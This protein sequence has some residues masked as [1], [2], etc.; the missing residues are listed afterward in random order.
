MQHIFFQKVGMVATYWQG[1]MATQWPG[2]VATQWPG[3]M[4]TQWP[5]WT[6]N[7]ELHEDR[8]QNVHSGTQHGAY[9]L[10]S[11]IPQ[12]RDRTKR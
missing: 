6:C 4:A 1:G 11:T 3:G 9:K 12:A 7:P 2:G 10:I 5:R 8:A